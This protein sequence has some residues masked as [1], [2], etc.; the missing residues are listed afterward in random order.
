[1]IEAS[2]ASTFGRNAEITEADPPNVS[3]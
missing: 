3:A 1:M 2:L